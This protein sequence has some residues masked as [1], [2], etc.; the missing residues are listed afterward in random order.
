MGQSRALNMSAIRLD[1][2]VLGCWEKQNIKTLKTLK[3]VA[4]LIEK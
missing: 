2:H 1:N 3:T 4:T